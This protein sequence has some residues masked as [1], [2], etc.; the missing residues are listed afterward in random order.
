MYFYTQSYTPHQT[1]VTERLKPRWLLD[2]Q[3]LAQAL[4]RELSTV[5]VAI[6]NGMDMEQFTHQK[7]EARIQRQLHAALSKAL[8]AE[9]QQATEARGEDSV[10]EQSSG[11]EEAPSAEQ[12]EMEADVLYAKGQYDLAAVA[13]GR[14]IDR[15]Q[16]GSPQELGELCCRRAQCYLK[17]GNYPSAENS[18][19]LACTMWPEGDEPRYLA[20]E[21]LHLLGE[22]RPALIQGR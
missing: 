13:Y 11:A 8:A 17:L 21:S 1:D 9:Q 18:A 20:V 16:G 19:T 14:D 12:E 15:A 5:D 3:H 6:A 2:N 4:M 10:S 22:H 7:Q